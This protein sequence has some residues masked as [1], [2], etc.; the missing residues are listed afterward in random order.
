MSLEV[1]KK[2][3]ETTQSLVRRFTQKVQKSGILRLARSIRFFQRP[4]SHQMKQRAALRR[5]ELKREYERK[6][7]LGEI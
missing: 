2:E 7:K 1:Q 4:K 3:K 5:E 6:K